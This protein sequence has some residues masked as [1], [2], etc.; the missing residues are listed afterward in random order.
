MTRI[1]RISLLALSFLLLVSTFTLGLTER[2]SAA[3]NKNNIISDSIFDRQSMSAAQIDAFLNSRSY[4]CIS[5]NSGFAAKQPTG[6]SPSAGFSFGNYVSAGNVIYTAAQVY[7]INPQVLLAT[8]Q[9]EQ[10]LV[11][12]SSAYCNNGDEH[13][14][15]AAAGYGCPDSGTT[16]SYTGLSLYRRNGVVRSSTGTT[17]VNSS[18]KA[19]FSQQVIRA[20]WL[21]KFGQQRSRGSVGWAIIEGSWDNSDDPQ[22]CYS[23]P[24]T[25]GTWQVCPSGPSTYYD[26]YRTIDGTAVFMG[27]GATAALYWYT[28]HL[29][30]NQNFVAIFEGWFGST[31]GACYDSTNVTGASSGRAVISNS[32][33]LSFTRLNNTK[34]GCTEVHTWAPGFKSWQSNISTNLSSQNPENKDIVSADTNGDGRDELFLVK[35]Q[36]GNGHVEIHVWD[37]V[38]RGWSNNV[39]TNLYNKDPSTSN[40]LAAD[41]NGDGR[42]ELVFI[43]YQSG[44]GK[45]EIHTWA[46]G[47]KSWT[48]NVVTNLNNFDS[49][50][51]R[52]V[53]G[54]IVGDG[55]DELMYVKYSATGSARIEIHTWAPG[56]KG[57]MAQYATNVGATT[58][59]SRVIVAGNT[60]G[61]S[62]DELMYVKY[63]DTG[64]GRVEVHTWA[65]GFKGWQSNA[66]TNLSAFDPAL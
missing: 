41:T 24:M 40:V 28:P 21:L 63:D 8:L 6:Y 1:Y 20:A 26:G 47:F 66:A 19:G 62:R 65:P 59:D 50:R 7:N 36:S 43:K 16:H 5:T 15:T 17:C 48:G 2:A 44:S 56:F 33:T 14:Y 30:G 54:N 53:A 27:S 39:V 51:G 42:D 22:S 29:H 11:Q 34:S 23:G 37:S 4:S 35:Y 25:R 52:I 57:W 64:S 45:V 58:P 32:R 55:R 38:Y 49:S 18:A 60:L 13:K 46:P 3:F 31:N 9:K 10:S 12:S 61:D